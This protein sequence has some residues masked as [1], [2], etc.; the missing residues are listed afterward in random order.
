MKVY[1]TKHLIK[2]FGISGQE[3]KDLAKNHDACLIKEY[4]GPH[5]L[6]T[7]YIQATS[8]I[9]QLVSKWN[10]WNML[11]GHWTVEHTYK[12]IKENANV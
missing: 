4:E 3:I 1:N 12:T 10:T 2:A 8:D 6:K 11:K 5:I 9:D 7:V